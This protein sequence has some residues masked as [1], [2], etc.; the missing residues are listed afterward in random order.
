M[1]RRTGTNS[2]LER[3]SPVEER[4]RETVTEVEVDTGTGY[5]EARSKGEKAPG[6]QITR[7]AV[8]SINTVAGLTPPPHWGYSESRIEGS[9]S[10][11]AVWTSPRNSVPA[12]DP[13]S[14]VPSDAV[15]GEA[16]PPF[17]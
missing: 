10:A 9:A 3:E 5:R 8:P 1:N 11:K 12:V 13:S 17:R 6:S 2:Y 7:A 14:Y 15:H 4:E 16:V